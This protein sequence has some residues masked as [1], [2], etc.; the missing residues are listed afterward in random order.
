MAQLHSTIPTS[1]KGREKWGTP[2][3]QGIRLATSKFVCEGLLFNEHTPLESGTGPGGEFFR[4]SL[5]GDGQK[6]CILG[7]RWLEV[8]VRMDVSEQ[9]LSIENKG[10]STALS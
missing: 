4:E 5:H 7:G 2:E 3:T 9:E 1:R 10:F 8:V 6:V